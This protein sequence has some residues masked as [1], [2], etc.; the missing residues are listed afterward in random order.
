MR[1]FPPTELATIVGNLVDNALEA[2]GPDREGHVTITLADD[3]EHAT[4]EVRDDGPGLPDADIFAAG[5]TTK[6][7]GPVGRGLGLTLV[8]RAT[9]ALG[10]TVTARNERRSRLH[11]DPAARWDRGGR[12][13]GR[14]AAR[15]GAAVIVRTLIVDDDAR[16]ADIHRGYTE[17]VEGFVVTGVANRG[18]EALRRVLRTS[19]TSCCSTSTC[20]I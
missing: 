14:P 11:R 6:P 4:I 18:T 17:R 7:A 3:G 9:T 5:V 15:G 20:P 10:G 2:L 1:G 12:R 13:R 16:V 8:R 19:P